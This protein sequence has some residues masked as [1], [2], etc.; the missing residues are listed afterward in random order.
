MYLQ[1]EADIPS[2][3]LMVSDA[4]DAPISAFEVRM[5]GDLLTSKLDGIA[6]PV[7]PG[8]HEF[9]FSAEGAVF[10]TQKILLAQGQRNR[11]ISVPRRAGSGREKGT[12][13][14]TV[15]TK[16]PHPRKPAIDETHSDDQ[17]AETV[18]ES[19]L[20]SS[21]RKVPAPE[22]RPET[23]VSWP[24]LALAG[25]GLVGLGGAGLL[26]YWGR[27]DNTAL[28]DACKPYCNPDSVHHIRMLYLA[29][30]ISAGLGVAA[31]IG[32][33]WLYLRS[34]SDVAKSS[35]ETTHLSRL[36]LRPST[37]GAYATVSGT[38]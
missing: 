6:I 5:D 16:S 31:L 7:N 10:A 25:V 37:S 23:G 38:F 36:D 12:A 35:T 14:E 9:T 17:N 28:Q 18:D 15:S 34:R 29:S 32:S 1:M 19:A 33:T 11:A 22:V 24:T 3:V 13:S 30:D 8:W 2:V 21:R 27:Q 26:S 20:R 4:S